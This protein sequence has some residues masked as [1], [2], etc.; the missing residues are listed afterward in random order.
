MGNRIYCTLPTRNY[1]YKYNAAEITI[2]HTSLLRLLRP[3]LIVAWLQSSNKGYA[4]R[5]GL[6]TALNNRRLNTVLLCPWLRARGTG[7]PFS[8]CKSSQSQSYITTN[9]HSA[10]YLGVKH[11]SGVQDQIF[12]TVRK[13]RVC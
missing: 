6:R 5:Y 11:P 4:S 13:L 9:G 1:S 10:V 3:P 7:S 12:I 8:D 2:T